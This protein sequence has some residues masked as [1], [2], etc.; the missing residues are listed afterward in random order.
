M[1]KFFVL[2]TG[3]ALIFSCKQSPSSPGLI[4][5]GAKLEILSEEFSFTEGPAS[6]A[7]GNVYFTDQPNDRIM[8]WSTDQKLSTWMQPSGRSNGLCFDKAGNLWACADEKNELWRITPDQQVTVLLDSYN[9]GKLNG[10]NDLWIAPNGSIYFSDPFYKR[11]WWNRDTTQQDGECVYF[12]SSDRQTLKRVIE[13]MQQPNGLIGTPDGRLLY[14]TDIKAKETYVYR[15]APDGSLEDKKLFCKEGS[16]GMTIDNQGNVYLTNEGGVLIF[17]AE[18]KKV[19]QIH[20]DQ[21]WTAN[22]CFGGKNMD[23]LF[24]TAK[25]GLYRMKMNVKGVSSQ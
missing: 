19:E 10:P 9:H 22:V 7:E 11:P 14:V 23:E 2:L 25:K 3:L 5:K 21:S 20:I 6:D 1:T 18:G 4:S 8:K 15:I 16:D 24:I 12:L 17:N 13:D